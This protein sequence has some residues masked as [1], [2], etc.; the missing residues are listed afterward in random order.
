MLSTKHIFQVILS[1]ASVLA[2]PVFKLRKMFS[3][4]KKRPDK[5]YKLIYDENTLRD[6]LIIVIGLV[7]LI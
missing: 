6:E 5:S 3:T 2:N 7:N 1:V 4:E